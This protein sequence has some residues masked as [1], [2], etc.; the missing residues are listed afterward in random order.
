MPSLSC[1]ANPWEAPDHRLRQEGQ[2]LRDQHASLYT[3][4]S[5]GTNQA[6][7]AWEVSMAS[8]K[9]PSHSGALCSPPRTSKVHEWARQGQDCNLGVKLRLLEAGVRLFSF[10]DLPAQC[11][12]TCY[13]AEDL[14]VSMLLRDGEAL[15]G[16]PVGGAVPTADAVVAFR[17]P[18]AWAVHHHPCPRT[19]CGCPRTPCGSLCNWDSL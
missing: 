9:C 18:A 8:A 6:T 5:T 10:P 19:P 7:G 1:L 2:C 16:R 14:R 12:A 15:R 17:D 11:S 13:D 4:N 3:F